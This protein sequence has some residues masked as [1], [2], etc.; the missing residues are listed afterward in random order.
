MPSQTLPP[1]SG[2]VT[3]AV[4]NVPRRASTSQLFATVA[5]AARDLAMST[6]AKPAS[7]RLA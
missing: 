1:R 4:L 6:S 7:I 2:I 3:A 5:L